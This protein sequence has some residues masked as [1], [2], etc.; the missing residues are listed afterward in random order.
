MEEQQTKVQKSGHWGLFVGIIILVLVV[1]GAGLAIYS[2]Q[3]KNDALLQDKTSLNNQITTLNQ[4]YETEVNKAK[5]T[6]PKGASLLVYTPAS[7][8]KMASPLAVVGQVP[9]G[10]SFE[11]SFPVKLLNSKGEVVAEGPATVLGDWMSGEPASFAVSLTWSSSQTGVG[12][13]VLAKDNPSGLP[14]NDDS[15]TIPVK[16]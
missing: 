16:F 1:A 12:S 4:K 7:G 6:S 10:W 11:A 14:A 5:F 13:L 2:L 9:G 3:R 8:S 15:L